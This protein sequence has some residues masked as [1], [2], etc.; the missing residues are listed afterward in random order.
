[1]SKDDEIGIELR[2][3]HRLDELLEE[4][5]W[6]R[7]L[8]KQRKEGEGAGCPGT[9]SWKFLGLAADSRHTWVPNSA[10]RLQ[11]MR[12]SQLGRAARPRQ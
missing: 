8:E 7:R 5:L 4:V 9:P 6:F 12:C 2:G 10:G 3:F 11:C 1:M